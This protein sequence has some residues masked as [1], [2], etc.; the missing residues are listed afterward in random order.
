MASI[1]VVPGTIRLVDSHLHGDHG[2]VVLQPHPSA[3]PEDPLNWPRWRKWLAIGM[4]YLYVFGIG[5]ATAV[6]YSVLTQIA[7]AQGL[8]VGQLNLGTGLMFL[9]LGW[10]CLLWQ[11]IALSYGRRGVYIV[12]IFLSIA[13]MLWAPYSTGKGQWYTHRILLGLF[14]APVESLPEVSVPDLFFAHERGTYMAYYAF[15]LFGSNFL[16][17]FFAGF[18]VDGVGWQWTMYFGAIVLGVC[19]VI[20]IFFMEDTIYFR[21]TAEGDESDSEK[22][23]AA[24]ITES[25]SGGNGGGADKSPATAAV[26]SSSFPPPRTYVQK[27]NLA[28]RLPGRP[29]V[30]QTLQKSWRALVILVTFP[31][32]T[33]AG[34][35]YGT[36]L[37]WYNVMNGTMSTILGGA[38]YFFAADMVGVAY[39]SPFIA[40]GI[41]SVWSGRF[42][43]A[44]ALRIARRNNGI[45]EAEH[46]LWALSIS[47]LINTGGLLLWGV[48]A[49]H[50]VHFMGLIFGVGF[51]TFGVVCGGAISLAYTVDCFKDV[52]GESMI[53]VIIIRNTV[54]FAFSWAITPWI[55]NLGLQDCF[56]SAA[57]IS[58]TCTASF[59]LIVLFGKKLRKMTARKYWEY[60]ADDMGMPSH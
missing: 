55:A 30:R 47:G 12:S 16:A 10:G 60:V 1:D 20:M 21:H 28:T 26:S 36:N 17:P 57:M 52:A 8:T 35:L 11:P 42:T 5:I 29:T 59:L 50:G 32:I 9:F 38:P 23:G 40:G 51:V 24:Q 4:V 44:M 2:D 58:L 37:S 54:G 43:D 15:I 31:N 3:D 41:A 7:D 56:I 46:R 45:R 49:A 6:Q 27:L 33:W 22:S 14:A 34:L 25:D 39:L 53:A 18:I 48:G 19:G 13:P